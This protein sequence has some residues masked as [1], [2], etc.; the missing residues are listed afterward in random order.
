MLASAAIKN[1]LVGFPMTLASTPQAY[2]KYNHQSHIY[3]VLRKK[4]GV[5][6][7]VITSSTVNRF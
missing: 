6:L 2:C 4:R 1:A 3:T 5:E 7:F